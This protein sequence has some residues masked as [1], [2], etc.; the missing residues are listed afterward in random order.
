MELSVQRRR[1]GISRALLQ[2]CLALSAACLLVLP[3]AAPALAQPAPATGPVTVVADHIEYNTVTGNVVADGHVRADRGDSVIT[4]DHLTGNL[5]TGDVQADGN[6]T[7]TEAGRT[8]TGTSLRYNYRTRVGRIEQVLTKYG[9]WTAKGRTAETSGGQI[10][11]ANASVTPCD[12]QHPAFLVTARKVVIVPDDYLTAYDATLYIYGV[13]VVTIPAY[14]ASLKRGRNA[15]SGPSLGYDS[16]E[17]AWVEYSQF[18]LIG[19]ASNQ[20]RV[21]Y[22]TRTG[23]SGEDIIS[24]R[25]GDHVWTAHLGRAQT[26]DQL[27]NE[28][29]LDQYSIDLA[30]NA[31]R[32]ANLPASYTLEGTGGN[33]RESVS[34]VSTTRGEAVLN[35]TSDLMPLSPSMYVSASGQAKMDVYGT[36]QQRT[37]LGYTVAVTDILNRSSSVTLSYN[38]AAVN[39][40][41]PF[42]FDAIGADSTV[43]LSYGYGGS[44]LL[45]VGGASVSYSFLTQQT[46]LGVNVGL[47]VTPTIILSGAGSYNLTISQW[48]EVDYAINV[49]CDCLSVGLLYRTF[50]LTPTQNTFYLTIGLT[51][52]PETFNTVKF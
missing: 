10:I 16:L 1:S 30:F 8:A 48:T 19:E 17:G 14:T 21:R 12:P 11:A 18:F 23:I 40:A 35:V 15:R 47:A 38:F 46:T 29:D 34:G 32:I 31:H 33:Y 4:A 51:P 22:A 9:P 36:G 5:N 26:F 20:F 41:S 28:F 43:A 13:P 7:L 24:Q 49:T 3:L 44:G 6:V 50:P 45:Q 25:F 37:V 52:F 2:R 39:G 27:G 42:Q